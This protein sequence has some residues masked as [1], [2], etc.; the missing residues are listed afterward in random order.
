MQ[1]FITFA[2]G[3]VRVLDI[4]ST[5]PTFWMDVRGNSEGDLSLPSWWYELLKFIA[6]RQRNGLY[7]TCRV[8]LISCLKGGSTFF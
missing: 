7:L 2:T 6:G 4:F 8:F 5:V 3:M 1:F